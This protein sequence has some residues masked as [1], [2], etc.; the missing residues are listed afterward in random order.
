MLA[1]IKK[2][3]IMIKKTLLS[4]TAL[5][6]LSG[7]TAVGAVKTVGL[8]AAAPS[9]DRGINTAIGGTPGKTISGDDA[10]AAHA[11]DKLAHERCGLYDFAVGWYD[12]LYFSP[13]SHKVFNEI[14]AKTHCDRWRIY[15]SGEL[16][17]LKNGL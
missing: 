2:V 6:L 9:I 3:F 10:R 13:E 8:M 7:C 4:L 12:I 11:G 17:K 1:A 15:E 16:E 5:T 14:G